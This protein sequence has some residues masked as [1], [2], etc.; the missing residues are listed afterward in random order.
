MRALEAMSEMSLSAKKAVE[1]ESG[2]SVVA[3]AKEEDPIGVTGPASKKLKVLPHGSAPTLHELSKK[4]RREKV[5]LEL[6]HLITN[7][8]VAC[9]VPPNCADSDEWKALWKAAVPNFDPPDATTL[10]DA[11][12]PRE[13]AYVKV[14]SL[15]HLRLQRDLTLTFDGNT[16]R[17]QESVYTVHVTTPDRQ[18]HLIEGNSASKVSHTSEH[19]FGVLKE[20]RLASSFRV[21]Y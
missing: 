4:A 17:A 19:I 6:D 1:M 13:A 11:L 2:R 18:V 12:I 9:G 15:K 3:E 7:F 20:V 10:R 14:Q 8:F 21:S 16:S 5:K